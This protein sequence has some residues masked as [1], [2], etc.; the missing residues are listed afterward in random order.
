MPDAYCELE[1]YELTKK[2]KFYRAFKRFCDIFVGIIGLFVCILPFIIIAII[3]KSD[4]KGP[5]L[6]VQP[7]IGRNG[8]LFK[9]FKFRTMR[10]DANHAIAPYEYADA[11]AN[12]TKIGKF[13]RKTSLDELPQVFN[14][15]N[16]TM[17]LI[18]YRPSQIVET[19]LNT[20]RE[21]LNLYQLYPGISGWA[22]INGR[23]ELAAKP[24]LKAKYDGYYLNN[25]SAKLDFKIFFITI[26][27][28]L[29]RA[30]VKEGKI[31]NK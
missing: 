1:P 20:A 3:I 26:C 4:S 12:I 31:E 30:D 8:K 23:D 9:C 7:R 27:K 29:R 28:V 25:F 15:L 22:Q 10:T 13:L 16:G 14:L 17:S 21:K 5:A 24:T 11:E 6:F 18:G 19:E 2:Q